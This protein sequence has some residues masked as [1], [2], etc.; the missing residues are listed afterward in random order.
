MFQLRMHLSKCGN[1]KNSIRVFDH[2]KVKDVLTWT[3]VI[4]AYMIYGQGKI[5]IIAFENM[6][7]AQITAD[8]IAFLVIIIACSHSGLVV[9][10]RAY[11][12]EMTKD[13]KIDPKIKHYACVVD[14]LSRSGQLPEA[15]KFILSMPMTPDARIWGSNI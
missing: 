7:V 14:L 3:T 10:G 6:K 11:F 5:A 9:K 1:L 15:G 2:I 13:Y 12:N 8:R 4:Y